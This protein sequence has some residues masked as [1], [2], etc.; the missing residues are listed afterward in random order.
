M[1]G[2]AKTGVLYAN[3]DAYE[4]VVYNRILS[5]SEIDQVETYLNDKYTIY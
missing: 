5:Q 2:A 4:L 1:M 3:F